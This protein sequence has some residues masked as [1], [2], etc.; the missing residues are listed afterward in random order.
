MAVVPPPLLLRQK[1]A[2]ERQ[3]LDL[4]D[5]VRSC[6]RKNEQE[7]I[8][9]ATSARDLKPGGSARRHAGSVTTRFHHVT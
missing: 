1:L 4:F 9:A 5:V 7:N 3:P 6:E 2:S 8:S